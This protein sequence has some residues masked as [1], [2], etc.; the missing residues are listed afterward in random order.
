MEGRRWI[1]LGGMALWLW[2]GRAD[3]EPEVWQ[4]ARQRARFFPLLPAPQEVKVDGGLE[5]WAEHPALLLALAA[6]TEFSL[7]WTG[8]R[9]SSAK[10]FF[11]FDEHFLYGAFLV[12]DDR[13]EADGKRP[14]SQSDHWELRWERWTLLLGL[15]KGEPPQPMA[16]G[17]PEIPPGLAVGGEAKPGGY[18]LEWRI[19][20][21]E[22]ERLGAVRDFAQPFALDVLYVD[23]DG[24]RSPD[25]V[26]RWSVAPLD[27]STSTYLVPTPSLSPADLPRFAAALLPMGTR[28][29]YSLEDE[30]A[31]VDV[32]FGGP[33]GLAGLPM[34][35]RVFDAEGQEVASRFGLRW[36]TKL[37]VEAGRLSTLH[38]YSWR[39]RTPR[40]MPQA[41]LLQAEWRSPT[42]ALLGQ[43]ATVLL[44]AGDVFR[45]LRARLEMLQQ[46]IE[47]A[48]RRPPREVAEVV[49]RCAPS[50]LLQ[51]QD[52]AET[53]DRLPSWS[54][55]RGL[56]EFDLELAQLED[57]WEQVLAGR[58][59]FAALRDTTL[60]LAYRSPIDDQLWPYSVRI[61][62]E[63]E[64]LPSTQPGP[65]PLL[66]WLEPEVR[67]AGRFQEQE[68]SPPAPRRWPMLVTLSGYGGSRFGR[69]SLEP[70]FLTVYIGRPDGD[71]KLWFEDDIL[72][73][74]E[75]VQQTWPV[76]PDRVYLHGGSMGGT[77]TWQIGVHYPDRFAALGPVCGNCNHRVWEEV[78][79]WGQKET[80]FMT[81]VRD[82]LEDSED[83]VQFAENL[84]N[85][86]AYFVHGDKD[87]IVPVGH[88]RTMAARLKALGYTF[89]YEELS[90][91]GHGVPGGA[92]DRIKRWFLEQRRDPYPRRVVFK[93][94][95]LRHRGAYWVEILRFRRWLRFASIE[96]QGEGNRFTV[97]T[98]NVARFALRFEMPWVDPQQPLQVWVDSLL[99]YQGPLP[100]QRRLVLE[101]REGTWQPAKEASPGRL[102][103]TAELCGPIEH[104][105]MGPYLLVYGTQSPDPWENEVA[106]LM[107][108][109]FAERWKRWS[110]GR[111]RL[112]A[113]TEVTQEDVERY[114]LILYG[115]P[116]VNLWTARI[117]P[118]LPIRFEGDAILLGE[119]R[120]QGPDVGVKMI[121]PNPL[122]PRRYVCIFAGVTWRGTYG[123][124]GRFG[125]WFDWGILDDR[126]WFDF[127]IFDERTS[128]PETFLAVGFFDQDWELDPELTWF[129]DPE[130]R[131][132]VAPRRVPT[133]RASELPAEALQEVSLSE[134]VPKSWRMER[135]TPAFDQS[136][137]GHPLRLGRR[138]FHQG[139]SLRPQ[140]EILYDLAGR[141]LT[142]EAWVGIDL[143]GEQ[144]VSP[145]RAD[146]E[147]V[148]FEVYGDGRL[149]ARTGIMRWNDPPRYLYLSVEGVKEL[150]L[151]AAARDGRKWLFGVVDWAEAKLEGPA[152]PRW[153]VA[154][155]PGPLGSG[156]G[157][158]ELSLE[159][160]WSLQS[161]E[162]GGGVPNGA[163]RPTEAL[164]SW[165][166]MEVPGT[167]AE[168][169]AAQGELPSPWRPARWV[170]EQ[171]WW[172]RRWVRIPLEWQGQSVELQVHG[173]HSQA[174]FWVNGHFV[175]SV[176]GPQ[177][178]ATLEVAPR[179]R[180][181]EPNFFAIRLV[182]APTAWTFP[183]RF[184]PSK[185]GEGLPASGSRAEG[186]PPWTPPGLGALRL[187][188]RGP[189]RF[190]E[191]PR[192]RFSPS[193]SLK[194]EVPLENRSP[195]PLEGE[196]TLRLA[197]G[198]TFALQQKVPLAPN[199][200]KP[201]AFE[202]PSSH[203]RLW[204][205]W[206]PQETPALYRLSLEVKGSGALAPSDR[207]EGEAGLRTVEADGEEGC[208]KVNGR[209]LRL[210]GVV[211]TPGGRWG[212]GKRGQ[213]ERHLRAIRAAGFN[214][215]LV[216][217][218][219]GW[220]EDAFYEL[221]D[222]LGLL[223]VQEWPWLG[224]AEWK[225][226]AQTHLLRLRH[227]PS[228]LA[229]LIGPQ[230]PRE[231]IQAVQALCQTLDSERPCL[232]SLPLAPTGSSLQE[233]VWLLEREVAQGVEGIVLRVKRA[234]MPS[235]P[236]MPARWGQ[237]LT[238]EEQKP[239]SAAWREHGATPQA[240]AAL[241][242]FG[243]L[244]TTE[245]WASVPFLAQW[246]MAE[247]LRDADFAPEPWAGG[248]LERWS[249]PW[250][251]FGP[252]AVDWEGFPKPA[253][254]RLVLPSPPWLWPRLGKQE[255]RAGETLEVEVWG[256][257]PPLQGSLLDSSWA[258]R[259]E[260]RRWPEGVLRASLEQ[261]LS[262]PPAGLL[263]RWAI[264]RW[265]IPSY[266][267]DGLFALRAALV[268]KGAQETL[269]A[270]ETRFLLVRRSRA[271]PVKVRALWLGLEPPDELWRAELGRYGVA[272]EVGPPAPSPPAPEVVPLAPGPLEAIPEPPP[273]EEEGREEPWEEPQTRLERTPLL[274]PTEDPAPWAFT[275]YDVV[276]LSGEGEGMPFSAEVGRAL[277]EAVRQGVGLL[278]EGVPEWLRRG[279]LR[280]WMPLDASLTEVETSAGPLQVREPEHPLLRG[281]PWDEVPLLE[282]RY[283]LYSS[284]GTVLLEFDEG[285][286][287]LLEGRVGRG[288]VGLLA[289]PSASLK[290][291]QAWERAA[292][293]Y[294]LLLAYLA[295]WPYSEWKKLQEAGPVSP[296]QGLAGLGEARVA[297]FLPPPPQVRWGE[298]VE[299][300]IEVQHLEGA[301]ALWATVEVVDLPPFLE[302]APTVQAFPL[303][304]GQRRSI[305]LRFH[306]S[307]PAQGQVSLRLRL[308]GWNVK[309]QEKTV[310]L[311]VGGP[312]P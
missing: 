79:G 286:P 206:G 136:F 36:Q 144:E 281:W 54:V 66:P 205:P 85:L 45:R 75:E 16:E 157:Y 18:A 30:W 199:E 225:S 279:G 244:A 193:A 118:L 289:L 282:E 288:R 123:I 239:H 171:E 224:T 148:E 147:K 209:A 13:W 142:F 86:P 100:A 77:G 265:P 277:A 290:A 32:L 284:W 223:V 270:W 1:W 276:I 33:A 14:L 154:S 160:S 169:L 67:D 212:G 172:L 47:G 126:N 51:L 127:G 133:K 255:W 232:V 189:L 211:W 98:E 213:M 143:E 203:L 163:H 82:F 238:A 65:L 207:W 184:E 242:G 73:V 62:A 202:V 245:G 90:G 243:S 12:A 194:I 69:A 301:P 15:G 8:L 150:K 180:F 137:N 158:E 261:P 222:R 83:A 88:S 93:T 220:E 115:G 260:V 50:L 124:N 302:M 101:L 197:L 105:F 120:F 10:V 156:R 78:W 179:L 215:V 125:N 168:A 130:E 110:L 5:E 81:P 259:L 63:G 29:N 128:S 19:P 210:R 303:E 237:F 246:W 216:E 119:R 122:S 17:L 162:R 94:A 178:W 227:H 181:G 164:P 76:D 285:H 146:A 2:M 230:V 198:E 268:E 24:G 153:A 307:H 104:A 60:L 214:A 7:R 21:E 28:R 217:A 229:W 95:W 309:P 300:A 204:Q 39:W 56:M 42:Q 4:T 167:V 68:P 306:L 195:L 109:E 87:D 34:L 271:S 294:A 235:A 296:W 9:D 139:V 141:F 84:A 132:K 23:W 253:L 97:R 190:M 37:P 252:G 278:C 25:S 20:W 52:L 44:S 111:P 274:S 138:R 72:R 280:E 149:L 218:E 247:G 106:R 58:N 192:L 46:R 305:P 22:L 251:A 38:G 74:I 140:A 295:G 266:E 121:Y 64:T 6:Q 91:A 240:L 183:E 236:P 191:P 165:L 89:R 175:G 173:A 131:A 135:G 170:E 262:A 272:L 53:Y 231:E 92:Y 273:I 186:L 208:W 41:Y 71:Y 96:A 129:G 297:W 254:S 304:R 269:W 155:S 161:F 31:E 117:H 187:R 59:P 3:A 234:R 107:A 166:K 35:L 182:A 108:E 200:V 151:V 26:L 113:D 196:V 228:L 275:A 159:G 112:K 174:D 55:R 61:P 263:S 264:F 292:E 43:S 114:H 233:E 188:T 57:W 293:F 241:K 185:F 283:R 226:L 145:A 308:S 201:L 152:A 102:E 11:G 103:K 176:R 40:P 299:W 256:I 219:G 80:T 250:P 258:V 48:E 298:E 116:Q 27:W 291:F 310:S 249:D 248:F 221:C 312:S 257:G 99:A 49:Q 134:L 177:S 70:G 267:E 311:T 287:V